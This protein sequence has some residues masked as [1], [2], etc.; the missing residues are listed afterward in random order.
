MLFFSA[1]L[2]SVSG[3]IFPFFD[4][5]TFLIVEQDA[6]FGLGNLGDLNDVVLT[7][8]TNN[9]VIV[10]DTATQTWVNANQSA[11]GG[12]VSSIVAGE[13]IDVNS[14][15][16]SVLVSFNV[17]QNIFVPDANAIIFRD[18]QLGVYSETD[19]QLNIFADSDIIL[20]SMAITFGDGSA[21]NI[22][23]TWNT[24]TNDGTFRW[25]RVSDFFQYSD[26]IL[27][28][29]SE[30]VFFGTGSDSAIQYDGTDMIIDPRLSGS[31][32]LLFQIATGLEATLTT[33]QLSFNNGAID[34]ALDWA[35]DGTL[36][37]LAGSAQM[38]L[39]SAQQLI[40]ESGASDSALDWSVDGTLLVITP[41][42]NTSNN[43]SVGSGT[44]FVDSNSYSIND[45]LNLNAISAN[46]AADEFLGGDGTCQSGGG[47]D[48]T[49]AYS[50]G[51]NIVLVEADN[52][53]FNFND[54]NFLG[55]T[56]NWT[57]NQ[58]FNDDIS[59]IF[60]QSDD[61]QFVWSTTPIN[62]YFALGLDL[63]STSFSGHFVILEDV[64]VGKEFNIPIQSNPTLN[65]R[66]AD[67]N[68][69]IEIYHNQLN[70]FFNAQSLETWDFNAVGG[71]L[72]VI[73]GFVEPD[74][75][76]LSTIKAGISINT[77]QDT[78]INA[79][80]TVSGGSDVNLLVSDPTNDRIGIGTGAPSAL[81]DL[82]GGAGRG[83]IEVDGDTGGCLKIQD[84]D[85]SGF[86]FC[87]A[88]NGVLSCSTSAC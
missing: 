48:A 41:D 50:A 8:E 51:G 23:T 25:N 28:N 38:G 4:N 45:D 35:T 30:G 72:R 74:G 2:I 52:N 79:V 57:G 75:N 26:D 27:M 86:T 18:N 81:V 5:Q 70:P 53:A 83:I 32:N 29:D 14:N 6:N 16:G 47:T 66:S 54:G 59:L 20:E 19:G 31:G 61:A 49:S 24:S 21:S 85:N 62:D 58:I 63:G 67:E 56:H 88:L 77:N 43:L 87:T 84:T 7:G 44:I 10:F 15:T 36:N 64:D 55:F 3:V 68:K 80:F 12:D 42:F 46:C 13:N 65:I 82:D 9:Q 22:V 40:F 60:G 1:F 76:G 11:A 69:G 39:S 78:D 37:F 17:D 73:G 33:N 71:G 34:T